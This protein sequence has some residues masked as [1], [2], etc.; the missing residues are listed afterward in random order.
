M[1][2][3]HRFF[4]QLNRHFG[5]VNTANSLYIS[6]QTKLGFGEAY[7]YG[8]TPNI[9]TSLNHS[10]MVALEPLFSDLH[11]SKSLTKMGI[12]CEELLKEDDTIINDYLNYLSK[13]T[14]VNP[15]TLSDFKALSNNDKKKLLND[16][17]THSTILNP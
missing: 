14:C 11:L 12:R 7:K 4:S 17:D 5:T 13:E 8:I 16:N 3:R 9:G 10:T 6:F 1:F 2:S 15:K